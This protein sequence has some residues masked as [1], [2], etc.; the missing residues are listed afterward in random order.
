MSSSSPAPSGVVTRFAPSPTGFLHI[1]GAR[2]A[3]FNWLYARHT[4]GKFLIRVEDTDRERSTE[5]AVA[6]IFEGLDWLGLKSDEEPIFQYSRAD[7]HRE[8]VQELLAKGRAYRCWMTVEELEAAREKARAEGRAIRSPWRDAPPPADPSAPHVIRFK[9]PLEGETLV[10]DMVKGPVTF[11]NIELDDLVLLRNDG[12]PTYNLAVVVDDHDMGVT[13]VIRG[14]DH[15]NNAAR[16]SLIYQAMEWDVP[17]FAHIPL[18]HGPDGAKLSKRH[19]AQAVGEF[20]DMGYIPE[21]LRNYLARLGWGHG[22][23]E[24]FNDE[25]AIS[26]F[27]VKDVVKAPARLDWAKLNFINSQHLR[28][29]DDTRLTALTLKALKAAGTDLPADAEARIASTVPQVKEGAKTILELGEHVAFALKV[30]PLTLEEKTAKQLSE[31]TVARLA[32]LR[33]HLAAAPVWGVAE[34]EALL[35]SFAESEAVGFGKF[36]PPLR[37]ILTG[38]AQAPDLNKIMAALGRDESLGRL[39]DALASRA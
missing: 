19:G 12:A 3:L 13:H 21:G 5:A 27:D 4:G 26:W 1:G 37:G 28:Q 6:A 17:A 38:G 36:G 20:A 35:K 8:V 14:D 22:D 31:E 15:L 18:I 7:R 29:A 23:D 10:D 34:L 2:T 33:E 16:Q 24:V 11:R 9:G 39:D 32:R 25:Q 30:R